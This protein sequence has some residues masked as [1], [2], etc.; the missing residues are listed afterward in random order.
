MW[1]QEMHGKECEGRFL[2]VKL[3]EY[4]DLPAKRDRPDVDIDQETPSGSRRTERT[5]RGGTSH[6]GRQVSVQK[7]K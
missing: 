3:D 2:G 4:S 6:K 7:Y 5:S 1:V